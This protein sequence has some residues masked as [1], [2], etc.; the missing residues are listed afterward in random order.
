VVAD[1]TFI[2]VKRH[3]DTTK[4]E[5]EVEYI[6]HQADL[7]LLKLKDETF[8]KGTKALDFDGLPKFEQDI[9]VYGFP[10]GG[11]SLSVSRGIVSRIE[12]NR[13]AHSREIF[14]SIQIDAAVNPGSSG[15]PAISDGKIVGVVMQQMSKSQSIGYI[16]PVEIVKHFLKDVE[17]K[18]YD[19]FAHLGV[20]TQKMENEAMRA[21]YK[22]DKDTTG[23]LVV[24]IS[25][26][27]SAFAKL[28]QGDIL[29]S[30]DGHK[31]QNDSTV[32][33]IHNKYTSY[34]YYID[35]KQIG[36]N[37]KFEVLRAGKHL[38]LD[39]E[40][41]T[42]ADDNLLVN[43]VAHDV[44]PRYYIYG[45]YVFTPLS[46]NLLMGNRSTL[47]QLREAANQ[48][49]S[50][51]KEEVVILLKV[52]ASPSNRGDHNFSLW[53]VDKADGKEFKNFAEF[54]KI[55]KA[56]DGKF[57]V[58]ENRDGVKIAIDKKEALKIEK[59]LLYRYSIES[60]Q[61]L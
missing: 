41:N 3:G 18:K 8:F 46:R 51:E 16:V 28:K 10:V 54:V 24:D 29:L 34:K 55:V 31:I 20:T 36:E 58:L 40:L 26:K 23:T 13:Y 27:S 21:I 2:E 1:E 61:R 15:G 38:K 22:M 12:H 59:T 9:A 56:F 47:L 7:A 35:K 49:S 6:S 19:G 43:T 37:I 25:Q 32:E 52:L 50:D 11:D 53:M 4:Y 44:M 14:L 45:G 5:A 39:I 48:W 42:I 30:I 57:L 33:F 17:D 60:S